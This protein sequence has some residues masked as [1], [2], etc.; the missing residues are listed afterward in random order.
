MLGA[1][2]RRTSAPLPGHS[3]VVLFLILFS[4]VLL[5]V[6][7][8]LCSSF[9]VFS[10][11]SLLAGLLLI[12]AWSLGQVFVQESN[13]TTAVNSASVSVTY[14][15]PETAGDLNVVVVAK[16]IWSFLLGFMLFAGLV[17]LGACG[18]GSS[19]SGGGG[20]H[21]GTPAGTY[22]ITVTG[23]AGSLTHSATASLTVQ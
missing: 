22:T 6:D 14:A 11:V 21:P 2:F 13:N 3:Q 12:P 18:G 16:K 23:T 1:T 15:A 8:N 9:Q 19:S 17:F 10:G 7:A 5:H 20:G 4:Y